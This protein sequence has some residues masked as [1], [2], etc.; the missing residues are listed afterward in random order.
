MNLIT[1]E[2]NQINYAG[3]GDQLADQFTNSNRIGLI[4]H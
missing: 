3:E 1:I 4:Y 2:R